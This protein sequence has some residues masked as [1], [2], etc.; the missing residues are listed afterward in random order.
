MINLKNIQYPI[1]IILFSIVSLLLLITGEIWILAQYVISLLIWIPIYENVYTEIIYSE[2]LWFSS[3]NFFSFFS[4]MF[5]WI[6]TVQMVIPNIFECVYKYYK[7]WKDIKYIN[8]LTKDELLNKYPIIFKYSVISFLIFLILYSIFSYNYWNNL[9]NFKGNKTI[10]ELSINTINEQVSLK[11]NCNIIDVID[12]NGS[13]WRWSSQPFYFT[14]I[15][16]EKYENQWIKEDSLNDLAIAYRNKNEFLKKHIGLLWK[17]FHI[18]LNKKE[19][20]WIINN[21][22]TILKTIN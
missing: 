12:W 1:W 22:G 11:I 2:T 17:D 5:L 15:K 7:S 10:E 16:C 3:I 9:K 13:I 18:L 14:K 20:I 21:K 6:I 19:I 8:L 4:F